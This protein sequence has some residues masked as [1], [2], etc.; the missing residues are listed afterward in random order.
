M[1]AV[2]SAAVNLIRPMRESD[3]DAVMSIE[4]RAYPYPW[5]AGIF[6]DCMRVGYGCWVMVTD[7][8]VRGYAVLSVAA[9]EAHL[10]NICVCPDWQGRGLGR[11]LLSHV[12]RQAERLGA[13]QIF[14]EVRPSNHAALRLYREMA[15]SEI[16]RRKGYYPAAG[17]REDALVLARIL[18][19]PQA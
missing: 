10:L 7:G 12:L 2:P 5:T 3:V 6:Q 15:F 14:L 1:S 13:G 9:G 8:G 16:G 4:S 17:G 19:L 18:G 11:K